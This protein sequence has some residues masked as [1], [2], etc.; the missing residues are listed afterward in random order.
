MS[1]T[2]DYTEANFVVKHT[3]KTEKLYSYESLK[4]PKRQVSILYIEMLVVKAPQHLLHALR[5]R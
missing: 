5:V 3:S 1:E 4:F 2:P